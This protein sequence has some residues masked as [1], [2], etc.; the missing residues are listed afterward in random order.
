MQNEMTTN[1]QQQNN[2]E[3]SID[4]K[5][6]VF[7]FL[8]HW[9]L[10]LIGAVLA[11]AVG[12]VI[13]RFKPKVYQTSGTVLIRDA[14]S[15][16]DATAIMT[17]SAFSGYQVVDNEIAILK[18]YTMTDRV[19]RKMNLEVTYLEKGRISKAEL[20][21]TSPFTV[22]FDRSVPQAVGLEYEVVSIGEGKMVIHGKAEGLNVYDYNLSQLIYNDPE[23]VI[24]VTT[25]CKLGE[26]V[27]NSYNRFRIVMND[28][29]NPEVDNNRKLSFWLNSY[30]SLV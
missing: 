24:D 20:Y 21:K 16:Y 15:S 27:D 12:Y 4:I 25:E 3:Q 2:E 14:H 6:L 8:S 26:M 7:I 19:V 5:Q 13:N 22:E 9:Y 29:Y 30:S 23:K 11:L 18:S 28:N 17:S 10:F 1:P